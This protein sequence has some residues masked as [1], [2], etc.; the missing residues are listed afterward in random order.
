MPIQTTQPRNTYVRKVIVGIPIR[1]VTSGA[2]SVFNLTGMNITNA[3]DNDLLQFDS[4][5]QSFINRQELRVLTVD[6]ITLDSDTISLAN[7]HLNIQ[8]SVDVTGNLTSTG[9]IEANQIRQTVLGAFNDSDLTTKRFVD[10]EVDKVKHAIFVTDDNFTDSISLYDAETFR[11]IG[12]NSISTSATKIGSE[13]RLVLDVDSTGVTPG[14]YGSGAQVPVLTVNDQGQVT[15]INTVAVAGVTNLEYDS[16]DNSGEITIS[17]A[18]GQTFTTAV[19]LSPFSTNDLKESDNLY[20]TRARFDSALGD[21]TSTSTIRGMISTS[22]DLQYDAN[23]G[24]ISVDIQQ[25]YTS[26][27]F[28]SDLDQAI[29]NSLNIHWYPDSNYFDLNVTGVDSGTFGSATEIPTFTVDRYGRLY[30][31]TTTTVAGVDSTSWLSNLNTFRINTADGGTYDQVIDSFGQDIRFQN[32]VAITLGST[33]GV[34]VDL[35]HDGSNF[36]VKNNASGKVEVWSDQQYFKT[37]DGNTLFDAER[38]GEGVRLFYDNLVKFQTTDSGVNVLGNILPDL[39]STYDLGSLNRRWKDLYLSGQSIYLGSL[40]LSDSDGALAVKNANGQTVDLVAKHARF[41]SAYISQLTVDS[42]NVSQLHIDSSYINNFNIVNMEANSAEIQQLAV[43]SISAQTLNVV[44]GDIDQFT[45]DSAYA[46]QLNVV[47]GDI[48]TLTSA[49]A[50]L[51]SVYAGQLNVATGDID[52]FTS[53][54]ATIDSGT[55]TNLNAVDA[56]IDSARITNLNVITGDIDTATLGQVSIDSAVVT[57]L[58]VNTGHID[59]LSVDSIHAT[60][61][62]VNVAH[63][64]ALTSDSATITN[65]AVPTGIVSQLT[66]DSAYISQF[67]AD[68]GVVT[69]LKSTTAIVNNKLTVKDGGYVLFE[70][71]ANTDGPTYSEGTLWYNQDAHT[72][73]LQGASSDMDIQIGEREWVR[74]RNNSGV[75]ISKGQPVY[76]T[77]VHIPGDDVHGHHPTI[78]LADASDVTKKDVLGLAGEDIADGAHGYVVVRGYIQGIDTSALTAGGRIHLGFSAPG[79]ITDTA[80]EYPNYPMDVGICLTSDT[81]NNGG[82]IYVQLYDHTFERFRVTGATRIDGNVTIAGNLQVLGTQTTSSSAALNV[83]D[84]FIYLGGGDTIGEAGTNF[85][86]IGSGGT[87]LDDA[88]ISG[89]FTGEVTTT[90]WVRIKTAGGSDII[91][92]AKDSDFTTIEYFDS[93]GT[94]LTEWNLNTDGLT[95][96]LAGQDNQVITFGASTGHTQGDRW[97]GTASPINVQIGIAGNYN[98]PADS[99]A[100]SGLFRD[101]SDQRWKFFQGYQPEPEGNI[102]TGHSTFALAPVQFSMGYGNL[103]GN[104]TGQV[105][106]LQNHNT[107]VLSEGSTNLYYTDTRADS[108]ARHAISVSD[109]GGDGSLSYAPATGIITYTGPSATEVRAHLVEGNGITYDSASGKITITDTGVDSGTYGSASLIPVFTVNSRGQIDSVGTVAVAGVSS[110]SF[111]SATGILTINTA[112]GGSFN[113]IIADSDFTKQRAR[114]AFRATGDL[115][116]DSATGTF[117]IDVEQIYTADNFDSDFGIAIQTIDGHLVPA[118]NETYDLGDSNYR[119]KDLYLSGNTINLG[120]TLI[121]VDSND[122]G[123]RF[124]NPAF[125]RVAMRGLEI[126]LG[127]V[128]TKITLKKHSTN[129]LLQVVDSDNT[130]LK[131]DLSQQTTDSLGEGSLNLYYTATRV[132]SD[133]DARLVGGTGITVASGDI[134]ITNT[135]VTAGTYGSASQVP[136]FTVNAQGQLDSAGSVSVAGVSSTSFDSATGEFTINTADGGSFATLILDSDFTSQRARDVMV[137][138]SNIVYDSASG[139]ISLN[140]NPSVADITASGRVTINDDSNGSFIVDNNTILRTY[141]GRDSDNANTNIPALVGLVDSYGDDIINIYVRTDFKTSAHRYYGSGSAKGYYIAFDSDDL[142]TAR[143]IQAPHL[144]LQPGTTY[145]FHQNDSSMSTHDI[146]FYFDNERNGSITDSA[147]KVIYSGSAGDI[148]VGNTWSQI[149]VHDYGPRTIAYQCLNHPYMGNAANTNTTGGGRIW[150]T[151]DGVKIEGLIYGT[152]DGGTY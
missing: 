61:L 26:E 109:V 102:N 12:G 98:N 64:D 53:A 130:Q 135:T 141:G 133:I 31:I 148:N 40:V 27:D 66:S 144:D 22:G 132:D 121:S 116:Y 107:D 75:S 149:R 15:A 16:S 52:T 51:D 82:S 32:D 131:Y 103:T 57:S 108:D 78:A 50:T 29:K 74:C 45:T 101:V 84:T 9:D 139:L 56:L 95:A 21:A 20:Y 88:T 110:T 25:V 124:H 72:L 115:S 7:D 111:D 11:I 63:I 70:P 85:Q 91:E 112:D 151:A 97:K 129:G 49:N 69:N 126:D 136:V 142:Y 55:I 137:A 86:G 39:D 48:D 93:A 123:V 119:W 38:L 87:G 100:H 36:F 104:V 106:S 99:Y 33:D 146:R 114:D 41:D 8:G 120:G 122:G 60:Q 6:E 138:G 59:D 94:G 1:K 37:G 3:S 28:D 118:I 17:T 65:L 35:Y 30:D 113:T 18:D 73:Y 145:R 128:G 2:F 34:D 43:D 80:P 58:N 14:E 42:L 143:E 96:T 77:G 89:H 152:L 76:V 127:G 23:T 68:S 140:T 79:A 19:T 71:T 117:S 134:S 83:S 81:A 150:S 125:D 90:Y 46:I 44:T 105:S 67:N 5:S 24:I 4:A 47:T 92:W 13:Y 54:N 147:A 10:D 62:D